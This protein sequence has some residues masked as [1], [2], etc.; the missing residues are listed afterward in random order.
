MKTTIKKALQIIG[1]KLNVTEISIK[2]KYNP[3][4]KETNLEMLVFYNDNTDLIM[5]NGYQDLDQNNYNS[6]LTN[7][8]IELNKL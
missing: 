3:L 4:R 7:L 6:L 2:T 1:G 5:I 8:I